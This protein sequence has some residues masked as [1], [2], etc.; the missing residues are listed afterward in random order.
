MI[1]PICKIC[2]SDA[3]RVSEYDSYACLVCLTWLEDRCSDEF[4]EFCIIRP[5]KPIAS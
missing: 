5:E 2:N 1:K 3:K 4:C